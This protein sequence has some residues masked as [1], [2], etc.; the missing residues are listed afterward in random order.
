MAPHHGGARG[1]TEDLDPPVVGGRG[2][3]GRRES[4][5][6]AWSR[7]AAARCVAK[8]SPPVGAPGGAAEAST[9][10]T[11]TTPA[12]STA[13]STACRAAR[14]AAQ[15][16]APSTP[17]GGSSPSS[18][19]GAARGHAEALPEQLISGAPGSR[20]QAAEISGRLG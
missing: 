18:K 12:A 16:A 9:T 20:G 13:A 1:E 2:A 17:A 3:Q 4:G 8:A 5:A 6:S 15:E 10:T 14:A 7:P 11:T 19:P